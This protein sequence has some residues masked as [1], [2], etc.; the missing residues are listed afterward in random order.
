MPLI[1]R[2]S[3]NPYGLSFKQSLMIKDIVSSVKSG[4]GLRLVDSA[5]KIYTPKNRNVAYQI[6]HKNI[7]KGNFKN[8]LMCELELSG[9]LGGQLESEIA[10]RLEEG[11][12]ATKEDIKGNAVPDYS[13]RLGYIKEISKLVS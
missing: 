3:E 10:H 1:K 11:L 5:Q 13:A 9:L 4:R 8:A 2:T 12:N 6:A 7:S